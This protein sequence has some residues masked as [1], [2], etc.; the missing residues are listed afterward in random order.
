MLPQACVS[1]RLKVAMHLLYETG[2]RISEVCAARVSDLKWV[3]YPGD[4]TD[5]QEVSGWELAVVGKSNKL[6]MVPVSPMTIAALSSYLGSRGLPADVAH[7][8]NQEAALLGQASDVAA[9]APGLA[10]LHGQADPKAGIAADTL[11]HQVK[12]FFESCAKVLHNQG[13]AQ[14]AKQ[15]LAASTHWMRHTHATHSLASG[16]SLQ[17]VQSILGHASIATTSVYLSTE[18]KRRMK[19]ME[20]FWRAGDRSSA[21]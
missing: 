5:S 4:A 9:R 14:G 15:F 2:L 7:P 19:A 16:T 18:D 20:A 1:D 6:R 17:V 3:V 10:K 13:D 21:Q 12:G 8:E 11:A